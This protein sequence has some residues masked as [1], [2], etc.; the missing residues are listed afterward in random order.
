ML[1]PQTLLDYLHY[2]QFVQGKDAVWDEI[3]AT[4]NLKK[5]TLKDLVG[6]WG[7]G[8]LA[9]SYPKSLLCD[10]TKSREMGFKE[11][12]STEK[13]FFNL[14]DYLWQNKYIPKPKCMK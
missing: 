7:C 8:D 1:P 3:V 9:T 10:M 5:K 11:Y 14:F 13:S 6:W 2:F 4:H 12:I